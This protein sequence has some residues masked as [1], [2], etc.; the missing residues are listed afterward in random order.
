MHRPTA[1]FVLRRCGARRIAA[2][3]AAV[4]LALGGCSSFNSPPVNGPDPNIYPANYKATM[5]TF[6]Q[7]NAAGIV[8]TASAQ[9]APPT[10]RQFGS[11][12]RYVA[13]LNASG[14]DD[15][16]RESWHKE[17]MFVFYGGEINQFIDATEEGCKGAAY[18]PFPELPAM[19]A[20][21][22][23]KTK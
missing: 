12:T 11:E 14:T 22:R 23:S 2:F 7:T 1:Y 9:L 13:C 6:L 16:R 5:L 21:L 8:G 17:K 19:L 3:S 4:T 20:Q 15:I 10:L 18:A